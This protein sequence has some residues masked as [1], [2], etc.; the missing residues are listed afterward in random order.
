V[1]TPEKGQ[2]LAEVNKK[3]ITVE[4]FHKELEKIPPFIR[5]MFTQSEKGK[6]EFL[7]DLITREVV[8]QEAK[9]QELE[10]DPEYLKRLEE[11]QRNALLE[12]LLKKEVE[13]KAP[14]AD[15][16]V[17]QF[18][19]AHKEEYRDDK[20]RASHI[21]VKTEEE[22]KSVEQ[23]IKKGRSFAE[24]AKKHSTDAASRKTG[25]DLGEFSRGQMIPE[26]ERAA[27]TLKKG[28]MSGIVRSEYGYHLIKVT[29]RK[30]GKLQELA[31]VSGQIRQKLVR[32][33]QRQIFEAWIAGLKKAA[34]IHVNDELLK[35]AGGGAPPQAGEA[36]AA[37]PKGE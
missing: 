29:D 17:K 13:D 25:G 2:V 21:L 20:V 11:F 3:P 27:F 19:A 28:E 36:P 26:F 5:P 30:E 24:L 9:R 18:Y 14:V 32:E 8:Y 6:R 12:A 4:E 23:E 35:S 34:G 1:P 15:E 33:K 22:A 16:E 37:K 7:D 10:K 31:Q